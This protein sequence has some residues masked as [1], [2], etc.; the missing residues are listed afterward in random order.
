MVPTFRDHSNLV[1]WSP[2]LNCG[3]RLDSNDP[4]NDKL[5][6]SNNF[7]LQGADNKLGQFLGQDIEASANHRNVCDTL[8]KAT[9]LWF[10]IM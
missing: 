10:H 9:Y 7:V 5:E 4:R 3:W 1:G 8:W 2:H 6:N